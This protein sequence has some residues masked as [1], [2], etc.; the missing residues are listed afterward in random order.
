MATLTIHLF[1]KVDCERGG[2][3]VFGL[4]SGKFQG[5]FC[6]LLLH[7]ERPLTREILA[8]MFW[9]GYTTAQSRKYLRQALWQLQ[10]MLAAGVD[11]SRSR[12]LRVAPDSIGIDSQAEMWLDV[13]MFERAFMQVQNIVGNRLEEHQADALREA[14]QLYRGELLEGWYQDWCLF[15]RERLQNIYLAML[16]KLM[17]YSEAHALYRA[18]LE[19]GERVLALDRA[20]ERTHQRMLRLLYL[21]GDRAGALR[22]FD[23]CVRSLA[24]ELDVKPAAR[25]LELHEQVRADSLEAEQFGPLPAP[26]EQRNDS[27]GKTSRSPLAEV[28][29]RLRDLEQVLV[30]ANLHL[31]QNIQV[32]ERFLHGDPRPFLSGKRQTD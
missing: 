1:G 29:N 32:V 9:G 18:G 11:D 2:V 4:H 13:E 22:Q 30:D 20:H 31:Q 10:G 12:V 26:A 8:N 14:V 27:T 23:R 3:P 7:R 6:Y 21:S 28:L 17:C 19:Y 5:L 24:E 25:T 15:H 16:D